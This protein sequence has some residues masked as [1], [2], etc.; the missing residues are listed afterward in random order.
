MLVD[1]LHRLRDDLRTI[2]EGLDPDRVSGSD[3]ACLL[4]WFAEV[5]KLAA[6][7][8]ILL[9]RRVEVSNV[10]RRTGHRSAA[11]HIAEATGTGLGPAIDTLETARRLPALPATDQ[12]L[13]QGRLSQAQAAV[14][15]T[16]ASVQPGAER[17]LVDAAGKEPFTTLRLRCRRLEAAGDER[18]SYEGVHRSRYLRHWTERDGGV[19]FD[20]RLAP[21]DGARVLVAIRAE[22]ARLT[23]EARA[24]GVTEPERA[25]A[26]DALV[27]LARRR[28]GDGPG[29]GRAPREPAPG[30]HK[31]GRADLAAGSGS[32]ARTAGEGPQAMVHVRVDYDALVREKVEAGELCEIPGVGPIPVDVARRL[33]ADSVLSVL[34]TD[35]VDVTAVAHRGRTIPAA[36]RRA[37][38]ERDPTCVV[39]GCEV[40]EHLEIDHLRPFSAGGPTEL[41]NLARL[42]HW[43]HYLKTHQGYRLERDGTRWC[44][45]PPPTRRS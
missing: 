33:A 9:A 18:A 36:V 12:A 30:E 10:W 22:A 44:W 13:R 42:C 1:Q 11:A 16:A 3:A 21:D 45:L 19:R 7:G 26:A 34:V 23:T 2:L 32:T 14:I 4:G 41:A 24:A 8:R 6:G 43:H 27:A 28:L 31:R 29:D 15:A 40:A 17:S 25:I 39:P 37:L 20:A 38:V 35:G 5:E